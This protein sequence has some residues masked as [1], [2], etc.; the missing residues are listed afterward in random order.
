MHSSSVVFTER[1]FW[2]LAH[3]RFTAPL[4]RPCRVNPVG[5]RSAYEEGKRFTEALVI[6]YVRKYRV[7]ADIVRLF[8]TYG[9]GMSP[10][11]QR[12]IPRFLRSLKNGRPLTIYG[13]GEQKRTFLFIDDLIS[14]LT[15]VMA[16]GGRGEVYR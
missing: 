12:V 7:D 8:N 14:A 6:H 4:I 3:Q 9:P 5:V 2:S 11:D 1:S 16:K 10:V 15:L 13:N